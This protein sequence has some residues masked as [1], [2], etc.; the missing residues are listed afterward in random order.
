MTIA[1]QKYN[2]YK[3]ASRI[4]RC[5]WYRRAVTAVHYT[6]PCN[7][8]HSNRLMVQ[9]WTDEI[10]CHPTYF[11][12]DWQTSGTP[13]EANNSVFALANSKLFWTLF[14]HFAQRSANWSNDK[15]H[16]SQPNR[17]NL[18]NMNKT[19]TDEFSPQ[20]TACQRSVTHCWPD[21]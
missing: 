8:S 21:W 1:R 10:L 2:N 5:A 19:D 18:Y 20:I 3:G 6:V 12:K 11:V 17:T 15:F 16:S 13:Q 9:A 14:R 7:R 4:I